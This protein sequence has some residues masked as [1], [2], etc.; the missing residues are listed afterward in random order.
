MEKKELTPF[1]NGFEL[2]KGLPFNM[3]AIW[4][5]TWNIGCSQCKNCK[6]KEVCA[7]KKRHY[8]TLCFYGLKSMICQSDVYNK[9]LNREK[10]P[11]STRLSLVHLYLDS[12]MCHLDRWPDANKK[13]IDAHHESDIRTDCLCEVYGAPMIGG[14]YAAAC[15]I[16]GCIAIAILRKRGYHI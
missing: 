3:D 16:F 11:L 10:E 1:D 5:P 8:E 2:E 13:P 9:V 12:M 15:R 6:A 7:V 4:D 14:A